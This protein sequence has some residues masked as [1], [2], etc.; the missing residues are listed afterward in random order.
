METFIWARIIHIL[1]VVVWIGGVAM[2]TH[3][4]Y[5]GGKKN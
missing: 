3:S 4:D 5:S 2:V 1:A